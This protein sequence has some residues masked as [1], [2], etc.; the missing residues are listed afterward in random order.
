M[1][2][3]RTG[4]D[5]RA[6]AIKEYSA[7]PKAPALLEPYHQIVLCQIWT[8]VRGI[9]SLCGGAVG[10]FYTHSRLGISDI[11][12]LVSLLNVISTFV[13]DLIPKPSLQKN[14]SDTI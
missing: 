7:F 5:L 11:F 2:P 6:M 12:G 8:F 3:L 1:V 13:G 4:V 9:L 10:V 14:S